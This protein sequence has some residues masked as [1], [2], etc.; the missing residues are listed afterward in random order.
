MVNNRVNHFNG[1]KSANPFTEPIREPMGDY[2]NLDGGELIH[3]SMSGN[4]GES[5]AA[6]AEIRRREEMF[7]PPPPETS[8]RIAA[9]VRSFSEDP[10]VIKEIV[11]LSASTI[12]MGV[13]LLILRGFYRE[14]EQ[15]HWS[16]FDTV[17]CT[18]TSVLALLAAI[19]FTRTLVRFVRTRPVVFCLLVVGGIWLYHELPPLPHIGSSQP[20]VAATYPQPRH[21]R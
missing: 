17:I 10:A 20:A 4:M 5:T 16:R 12:I 6:I 11:G 1:E 18:G 15:G 7:N 8:G 14:F 2:I 19:H 21:K 3:K 13:L 9:P